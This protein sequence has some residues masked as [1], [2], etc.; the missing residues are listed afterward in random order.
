VMQRVWAVMVTFPIFI[1][2]LWSLGGEGGMD[3]A[4]KPLSGA[5][6]SMIPSAVKEQAAEIAAGLFGDGAREHQAFGDE[7]LRVYLETEGRDVVLMWNPGGVGR[8]SWEDTDPEWQVI[9]EGIQSN[10]TAAG[11]NPIVI[12]Y[13]RTDSNLFGYA[14]ELLEVVR[15]YPSK[16]QRLAAT[17]DFLTSV[18]PSCQ[19]V[20]VGLCSGAVCVNEAMWHLVDNQN[21]CSIQVGTPFWYDG[22]TAQRSL[23]LESNGNVPDYFVTGNIWGI[24]RANVGHIP[25]KTKPPG[26]AI[27]LGPY[28]IRVPG[29]EY[30]WDMPGV[31]GQIVDFLD[32]YFGSD[33]RIQS[34]VV[35]SG[36]EGSAGI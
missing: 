13:V 12:D 29:H 24:I 31:R 6:L 15:S 4:P 27:M 34:E 35:S 23:R 10:L 36:R 8:V 26:G 1:G 2:L 7:L 19:V 3:G 20:L 22:A 28:Y 25:S 17:V 32:A 30:D 9:I 33:G 5:E 11:Y 21:V 18:D 14:G 16:S